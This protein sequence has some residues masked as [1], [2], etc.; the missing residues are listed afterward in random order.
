MGDKTEKATPKKRR[1]ERKKGHVFMS[2]DA[3]TVVS[4]FAA[5]LILRLTFAASAERMAAFLASCFELIR[6]D[7]IPAPTNNLF[8]LSVGVLASVCGPMMA[9]VILAVVAATM[10]QT[11]MLVSFELIKPKFSKLSPLKGIKNLF[12]L[13]SLVMTGMNLLKIILLLLIVYASL[14]DMIGVA[15]RYMYADLQGAVSHILEAIFSMLLRV[16]MAFTVLAAIDFMYQWFHFEKEMR[17]SKQEIKEEYKQTEGDPQIKGRIR[18]LQRQ[19]SQARMMQQVPKSDVVVRN[20]THVAVALR[21]HIGEDAAPVVLAMGADHLA[22]KIVEVAESNDITVIENVALARA[23]YAECELN[24][25]I[26]PTLYEAVAEVMV[27][28]Y[29]LGRLEA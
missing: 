9:A 18:Q 8:F 17:M 22:M 28:L 23:M 10:A 5:V 26:P 13:K 20:P 11:K 4:L 27:Y 12:S 15:E 16:G 6:G 19:M 24:Q 14:R 25:P 21:Y 1:D 2:K 29:K 3:V 7:I